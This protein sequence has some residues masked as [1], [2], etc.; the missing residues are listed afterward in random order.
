MLNESPII[1]LDSKCFCN[2]NKKFRNC[3]YRLSLL[4][5][6]N[7]Y[8]L[9]DSIQKSYSVKYPCSLSTKKCQCKKTID[10]HSVQKNKALI[11][12]SKNGHVLS[13]EKMYFDKTGKFQF[14]KIG[15]KKAS[16]FR[17]L[18]NK[19]DTE[20][21]NDIDNNEF[22]G[23]DW[24]ILIASLRSLYWSKYKS[25]CS[26]NHLKDLIPEVAKGKEI[27]EQLF[28]YNLLTGLIRLREL[29]LLDI[30]PIEEKY[31]RIILRDRL[32]KIPKTINYLNIYLEGNPEVFC[33]SRY[34]PQ[35]T[36][37]NKRIQTESFDKEIYQGFTLSTLKTD[38]GIVFSFA[39][40]KEFDKINIFFEEI[41]RIPNNEL[42][43][44]LV[45]L[46]FFIS[47]S[48]Y[49][50]EDWWKSIS[51]DAKSHIKELTHE[52]VDLHKG[53]NTKGLKLSNL[54]FEKID[55]KID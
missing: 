55:Y 43:N 46:T 42:P 14:D 8:K 50:S 36:I 45:H 40:L 20:I 37:T 41:L 44:F 32:D 28:D 35:I 34:N 2:S 5:Q 17:L 49:F 22:M 1:D 27:K 15:L 26:L 12:I 10:S 53:Y 39:W 6:E 30:K 18:C 7:I 29:S 19:H 24:Q 31:N 21:F 13:Y 16:T 9:M 4:P 47:E 54:A 23:S 38:K 11:S 52:R 51:S 33:T 3:H 25:M 48:T